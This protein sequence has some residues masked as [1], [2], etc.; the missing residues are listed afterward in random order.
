MIK[1]E[2]RMYKHDDINTITR[3]DRDRSLFNFV[4]KLYPIC[5]SITGDG[6]RKSLKLIQ[7]HVPI[8]I[9]ETP[10]GTNIFDW[11]VPK[12][13]NINDAW[14]KNSKG[15]KV[16]DF[17]E[18]NLH[19]LSY[20]IPVDKLVT[21][22]ELKKH[23]YTMPEQPELIPYRTSYYHETW[24]F[25]LSYNQ[26]KE[27]DDEET[28]YVHIDS[29]LE[30]GSL[31]H[32]EL[33]IKGETAEEVLISTHICHPSLCNDNLSGV[34]VATHLAE[35]LL[36]KDLRYSYRFLFI[37][38]T[39]GS[40][41]WLAQNEDKIGNIKHGL[42]LSCVGDPGNFTYKKSRQGSADI[43]RIVE[44][45]LSEGGEDFEVREF[46]PY[47]YDERQYCSP[48]FDLPV[49]CFMRT[50]NGEFPEYHTSADNLSFIESEA[51]DDS[52]SKL[53]R[54][55]GLIED[56]HTYINQKPKC[57]PNLGK[58]G[59]YSLMGGKAGDEINQMAIL[60]VLNLSDGNHSLLDIAERS[61]MEFGSIKQAADALVNVDLVER[62]S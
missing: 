29:T 17:Q 48:A 42:V 26:M 12:E 15:E 20:S 22:D 32:G 25:C 10:T 39:I 37:P 27:M 55:V 56:N 4:K 33:L 43:D 34:S 23:L 16:V 6:V 1:K 7:E 49:G 61:G 19:V 60:W 57:E 47:G 18:S 54:V 5:R 21:Y 50:P 3:F 9:I 13:W 58:R 36:N 53:E 59:L 44:R 41:N 30:E 8:D 38:G 46:V 31:T 62:I 2:S 35:S 11:T 40:I 24:G 52:L 51:L 14:I 28:Y 45:V